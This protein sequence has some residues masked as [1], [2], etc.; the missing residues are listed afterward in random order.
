M[1]QEKN[2]S[3]SGEGSTRRQ[4]LRGTAA[5]AVAVVTGV[6]G[7]HNFAL[8]PLGRSFPK[9]S[10]V[11]LP[12]PTMCIGC[13]TCEVICGRWHREQELSDIPRINIYYDDS[14]TLNETVQAKYPGRGLFTIATCRMCPKP[15][16]ASACP[17]DALRIDKDTGARYIDESRC[18]ACG[19]CQKACPFYVE[20][21]LTRDNEVAKLNRISYDEE[22]D[23]Y[24]KCDLC[25]GREEG[26]ICVERCPINK[27][28]RQGVLQLAEDEW[29]LDL[30]PSTEEVA[31]RLI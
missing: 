22:R 2:A 28:K 11:V 3:S 5:A 4:F 26:P 15:D 21:T 30:V 17:Y 18:Q 29:C 25:R 27:R 1:E 7:L 31:K 8:S 9:A 16:C 13:M 6:W 24:V 14:V 20:G 10:G 23:V 12:D 19:R